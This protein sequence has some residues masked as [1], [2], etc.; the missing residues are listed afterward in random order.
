MRASHVIRASAVAALALAQFYASPAAAQSIPVSAGSNASSLVGVDFLLP[1][2]ID[3]S[4][5]TDTLQSFALTLRWNASVL[6]LVG[7]GPGKF[8]PVDANEDLAAQ[9]ELKVTGT[10]TT[11]I[12]GLFS[13]AVVRMRPLLGD[14]TTFEISVEQLTAKTSLADLTPD[15]VLTNRSYCPALGR[16]GDPDGNG[17]INTRDALIALSAA[18]GLDVSQFNAAMAD[19]DGDGLTQAVDALIILSRAL[20]IDVS[21]SRLFSIAPGSCAPST[22]LGSFFLVPGDTTVG[23]G[24]RIEYTALAT[25]S[26]GA[27]V[28]VADVF[29]RVSNPRVAAVTPNGLVQTLDTGTTV[30]TAFRSGTADSARATVTVVAAPSPATSTITGAPDATLADGISTSTITVQL[31]DRAGGRLSTGGAVVTLATT[32]GTLGAVTDNGDGTYTATLTSGTATGAATITGTLNGVAMVDR[33]TV[34]FEERVADAATSTITGSPLAIPADGV[35]TSTITVQLKN[36]SGID[37]ADGGD[38][39]TLATTLGTLGAVTDNGDADGAGGTG[40]DDYLRDREWRTA[41]GNP[42]HRVRSDCGSGHVDDHG[43]SVE[44]IGDAGGSFDHHRAAE[45]RR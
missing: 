41:V 34:V 42:V 8:G 6:E 19:V 28:V 4:Q 25:D 44:D 31:K 5:R 15:V 37:L 36:P 27:T 39:V 23:T 3:M 11:S 7:G 32:R 30:V 38:A 20:G 24:S 35:S 10:N 9:G 43:E 21:G 2:E 12:G 29:W 14:T 1:I 45:G 17:V 22:A 26:S 13:V 18:V 33:A 16:W 40:D